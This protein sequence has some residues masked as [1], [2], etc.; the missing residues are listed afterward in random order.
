M[1]LRSAQDRRGYHN[2][3]AVDQ[4]ADPCYDALVNMAHRGDAKPES[5]SPAMATYPDLLPPHKYEE[6]KQPSQGQGI[7]ASRSVV[8][9]PEHNPEGLRD[10]LLRQPHRHHAVPLYPHY[11]AQP[12]SH[13][14]HRR[15]ASSEIGLASPASLGSVLTGNH[16]TSSLASSWTASDPLPPFLA[17]E[18][19]S[20]PSHR[21][22]S[23][24]LGAA[25]S[26]GN[27]HYGAH[28]RGDSISSTAASSSARVLSKP[29]L[30]RASQSDHAHD[31]SRSHDRLMQARG[32]GIV[33]MSRSTEGHG[34]VLAPLRQQRR[35]MPSMS[36]RPPTN[37][38]TRAGPINV[39]EPA[40]MSRLA[41]RTRSSSDVPALLPLGAPTAGHGGVDL[42]SSLPSEPHAPDGALILR[43]VGDGFAGESRMVLTSSHVIAPAPLRQG[44][45]EMLQALHIDDDDDDDGDNLSIDF[46]T[47]SNY[48]SRMIRRTSADLAHGAS[49][50]AS[51]TRQRLGV[52][53]GLRKRQSSDS[54]AP[55][56]SRSDADSQTGHECRRIEPKSDGS[57]SE[58][59]LGTDQRPRP[60]WRSSLPMES[61]GSKEAAAAA[62][63]AATDGIGFQPHNHAHA[64]TSAVA[65]P[66]ADPSQLRV[67]RSRSSSLLRL[68]LASP[69]PPIPE[70]VIVNA[71]P[72]RTPP[73]SLG[74]GYRRWSRQQ[75]GD[76]ISI[77]SKHG[78]M[79]SLG[80]EVHVIKESAVSSGIS[81][82]NDDDVIA[83]S[84][85]SLL[86]SDEG[87]P[88]VP[89]SPQALRRQAATR[90]AFHALEEWKT[91][92]SRTSTPET[93]LDESDAT[94][95][96][97]MQTATSSSG[98]MPTTPKRVRQAPRD[99]ASPAESQM[100]GEGT[101]TSLSEQRAPLVRS[102][103]SAHTAHSPSG[104]EPAKVTATPFIAATYRSLA[105]RSY[106]VLRQAFTGSPATP[107]P[108][109]SLS[110][111]LA[112]SKPTQDDATPTKSAYQTHSGL[113]GSTVALGTGQ[114]NS[115]GPFGA[116]HGHTSG[117]SGRDGQQ[118]SGRSGQRTAAGNNGGGGG[119]SGSG[120][121]GQ[122]GGGGGGGGGRK[123]PGG[124]AM[125]ANAGLDGTAVDTLF[126]RLELVGRGAYGAVYRGVHVATGSAVALKVVNLDT[127]DDDVSDIQK[128]VALLSQL[129]EAEQKNVVRY[130]GCWLKGPELWI[131]MDFAEGGSVRT[132]MR[133]GPIAEQ[134]A[135][136]IV[137]ETLVALAYLHKAGVIHR[138]IKAANILLTNQGRILLCDFGVAATLVSSASKRTTFVGTP[139][140][141]APEVITT[142]KT[143][144]QSADI[145]SLGITIYEMV[146]G[147]PPLADQEQMRA[148]M[149]I[150]KNKPPRLPADK[151]YS[152]QMRD[153]VAT[154]LNEEPKERLS[155][156]ELSRTKWIK[157]SAKVGTG[158]LKELITA[159]NSWTKAGGMRLSLLGAEAADLDAE[160]RDAF[161][162]DDAHNGDAGWEFNAEPG[163]DETGH[164]VPEN[165]LGQQR[166]PMTGGVQRDHPLLRLFHPEGASPP[167]QESTRP[168]EGFLT[169]IA[170]SQIRPAPQ[171]PASQHALADPSVS[172]DELTI[173][174]AP[175]A[176]AGPI[177]QMRE[178]L[179]EIEAP[180]AA[181]KRPQPTTPADSENETPRMPKALDKP[182]FTGTGASP[183]RFGAPIEVASV[184]STVPLAAS[185]SAENPGRTPGSAS[186]ETASEVSKSPSKKTVRRKLSEA[187]QSL[188]RLKQHGGGD[189]AQIPV[190][191]GFG[192]LSSS[193]SE[194]PWHHSRQQSSTSANSNHS[195]SHLAQAAQGVRTGPQSPVGGDFARPWM[196]GPSRTRGTSHGS[197]TSEHSTADLTVTTSTPTLPTSRSAGVLGQGA[198]SQLP[199]ATAGASLVA[200]TN[201]SSGSAAGWQPSQPSLLGPRVRSGSRSRAGPGSDMGT[202]PVSP[203]PPPGLPSARSGFTAVNG[204]G[205]MTAGVTPSL[206]ARDQLSRLHT[207]NINGR[208]FDSQGDLLPPSPSSL[209]ATNTPVS[210]PPMGFAKSRSGSSSSRPSPLGPEGTPLQPPIPLHQRRHHGGS[211][212]IMPSPSRVSHDGPDPVANAVAGRGDGRFD[213]PS[214]PPDVPKSSVALEA[215]TRPAMAASFPNGSSR[216]RNEHMDGS[217]L[218]R[219]PDLSS[220][221]TK[222]EV[223][224]ELD[225]TVDDL[226]RWLEL[227]ASSLTL[228]ERSLREPRL[229]G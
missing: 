44:D 150:P 168:L 7:V 220:L 47:K 182:S 172:T 82:I 184:P 68:Q 156:E 46:E 187:D 71:V 176:S 219:P 117:S 217:S 66:S 201:G 95:V 79:S 80:S 195:A 178:P 73:P 93:I 99:S 19:G 33:G 142:G 36:K 157:S 8:A 143:Y 155:A 218:P 226:G 52:G 211:D 41:R 209:S 105:K 227:L 75:S 53:L 10:D 205:S 6:Q 12:S 208:A 210:A 151:E 213:G 9:R 166:H 13:A 225:R 183:F 65:L 135:S 38:S 29:L 174:T 126:K 139:Y 144:D 163:E 76:F 193:P 149:L 160:Q 78:S 229:Q 4:Q 114:G 55:T 39:H 50:A 22:R 84:L 97:T 3:G 63:A 20:S 119:G 167:A 57:G 131:V 86:E 116:S 175:A 162:Y 127:P 15:N 109:Q 70:E 191:A 2:Q 122:N 115:N 1:L 26:C 169:N 81:Q 170:A 180:S 130:W 133:A 177:S 24:Q 199:P 171:P 85:E 90:A 67:G 215:L 62:A 58:L 141:M 154:C 124:P 212:P 28:R 91:M 159:Y 137:R 189:D 165:G 145:W 74:R 108:A 181:V 112:G 173:D 35:Q 104:S 120:G 87:P 59:S 123:P 204:A 147:N 60:H 111:T 196:S 129:R 222:P 54:V 48:L 56:P 138:D 23:P 113:D 89:P 30:R 83:I 103:S 200:A 102:L 228:S 136:I 206:S 188:R 64:L 5:A 207:A 190:D 146:T 88:S 101:T 223:F 100:G 148:I 32:L 110:R 49:R 21:W 179:A 61:A 216:G 221:R 134:F 164:A 161:A 42:P 185:A 198:A 72:S 132:L 43:A 186:A 158:I 14:A 11:I 107:Q 77:A 25:S 214:G 194:H 69:T 153:F 152:L 31:L 51:A 94:V 203:A 40:A 128:E 106:S 17:P 92:P 118:K 16:S 121:G 96:P 45:L 224:A 202:L 37:E 197:H 27:D 34:D 98:Q 18:L 125:I 140:W 192:P